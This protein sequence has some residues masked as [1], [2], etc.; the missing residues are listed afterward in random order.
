MP[1]HQRWQ[2]PGT[3]PWL[4]L[5]PKLL[6]VDEL[7]FVFYVLFIDI[8]W[9]L[10]TFCT[11]RSLT[12]LALRRASPRCCFN[13]RVLDLG[14]FWCTPLWCPVPVLLPVPSFVWLYGTVGLP[15]AV[16]LHS[17]LNGGQVASQISYWQYTL[18]STSRG[19]HNDHAQMSASFSSASSFRDRQHS[20]SP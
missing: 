3:A 13:V 15:K 8:T 10:L 12:I 17:C 16:L 6:Y 14:R 5:N 4:R 2:V 7:E 9:F 11:R 20:D 19:R 18:E 1:S